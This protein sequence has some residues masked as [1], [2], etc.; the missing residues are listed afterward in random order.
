MIKLELAKSLWS[1]LSITAGKMHL[2]KNIYTKIY[3]YLFN[4]CM[5]SMVFFSGGLTALVK[6]IRPLNVCKIK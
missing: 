4:L 2:I 1:M 3:L 6:I 5:V